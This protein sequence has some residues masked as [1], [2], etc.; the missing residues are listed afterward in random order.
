MLDFETYTS[1]DLNNNNPTWDTIGGMYIAVPTNVSS[2]ANQSTS[3]TSLSARIIVTQ[4]YGGLTEYRLAYYNAAGNSTVDGFI[5]PA[6][7]YQAGTG[8]PNNVNME[9][10]WT[11]WQAWDSAN[12][13]GGLFQLQARRTSAGQTRIKRVAVQFLF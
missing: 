3:S 13:A 10:V 2:L 12:T 7:F 11:S 5:T 6:N 4:E 9:T 1:Y 8:G